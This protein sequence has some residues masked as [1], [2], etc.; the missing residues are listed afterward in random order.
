MAEWFDKRQSFA[1]GVM[2]GASGLFGAFLPAV[3]TRLLEKFGHKITLLS[4][5][6]GVLVL[7]TIA[8]LCVSHRV[9]LDKSTNS[10]SKAPIG[11]G[12]LRK[13]SFYLLGGSVLAQALVLNI[14]AIYL[15]SFT[16][17]L[18]YNSTKGSI[19]LSMY[20][21]ASAMG[22][23]IFGLLAYVSRFPSYPATK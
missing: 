7:T 8:L 1:Y 3:Y 18:N 16:I 12:Y 23:L 14:P 21:L 13:A 4:H 17:D 15:P 6:A 5:G 19:T 10:T 11:Y 20:N 2:F 9:P 22:Q